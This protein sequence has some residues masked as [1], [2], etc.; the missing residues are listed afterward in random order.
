MRSVLKSFC[1]T[2]ELYNMCC[3]QVMMGIFTLAICGWGAYGM[4]NLDVDVTKSGWGVVQEVRVS[5]LTSFLIIQH[6]QQPAIEQL[7]V[8]ESEHAS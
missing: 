2:H 1:E 7:L 6:S 3:N 8:H 5:F 4:Y